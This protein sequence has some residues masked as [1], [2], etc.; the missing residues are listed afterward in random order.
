MFL[1][2]Q[3]VGKFGKIRYP[4]LGMVFKIFN[5]FF[6]LKGSVKQCSFSNMDQR[7]RK[8]IKFSAKGIKGFWEL[9]VRIQPI[10]LLGCASLLDKN[11]L[12]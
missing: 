3:G 9:C 8:T 7:N 10:P 4:S 5:G 6:Q 12:V 11:F 1:G 2:G